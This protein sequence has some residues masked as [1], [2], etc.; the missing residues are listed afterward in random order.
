MKLL[1]MGCMDMGQMTN[2]YEI[3]DQQTP[4][5]SKN[6]ERNPMEGY[7]KVSSINIV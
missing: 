2:E 7:Y 3:S 6:S 1:E 4:N 5:K